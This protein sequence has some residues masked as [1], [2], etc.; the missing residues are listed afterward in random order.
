[1][2]QGAGK[3]TAVGEAQQSGWVARGNGNGAASEHDLVYVNDGAPGITRRRRGKGFS[4]YDPDGNLIQD[5]DL[6]KRLDSLAIPPA[7][8]DV[9][10]CP[11][12]DG[13]LQATGRDERGRKQY[14]YHPRWMEL[15]ERDKFEHLLEFAESLPGIRRRVGRDLGLEGLPREKVLAAVVRL[16]ETTLARVG[17]SSYAKENNSYGLTTIRKKHV[18]I[19]DDT[20]QFEFAGKGGQEWHVE[21]DDPRVMEVVRTCVEIPG[22][23]LFKYLGEDGNRYDVHSGHV[24]SYLKEITGRDVTAKDFRTWAATVLC[25]QELEGA[26]F[27]KPTQ[28]KRNIVTAVKE[29][30]QVLGN[31]PAVCRKSYV[32]PA[33]FDAYLDGS[34]AARLEEWRGRREETPAGLRNDERAVW[35]LL[36]ERTAA[37][38]R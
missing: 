24:N 26:Q 28:A 35:G 2:A 30:A 38:S 9:W 32:H 1:M 29:V 33:V 8:R 15:R 16:L 18:E 4:Y 37:P 27:E 7:Y 21:T 22:Y 20:V 25:A 10:I 31:T 36:T 6:R 13:H 19:E 17:N 3:G 12:P 14:I 11:R 34:L 5:P 23:E